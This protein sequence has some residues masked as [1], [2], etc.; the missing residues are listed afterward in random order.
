MSKHTL[1]IAVLLFALLIA[2]VGSAVLA[3][4]HQPAVRS[5]APVYAIGD[6]DEPTPTPTPTAT[7]VGG[8]PGCGQGGGGC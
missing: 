7:P 4:P 5:H 6:G 2:T 1:T 3:T 8:G